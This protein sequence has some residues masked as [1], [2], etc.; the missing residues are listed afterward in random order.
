MI[1]KAHDRF[2][3]RILQYTE[4]PML[5]L[6]NQKLQAG[7]KNPFPTYMTFDPDGGDF[8]ED[9]SSISEFPLFKSI[10]NIGT[11]EHIWD[12]HGAYSNTCRMI[13]IGGVYAGTVPC[14]GYI[15]H[16]IHVT[17][18]KYIIDFLQL[19]GFTIL[20]EWLTGRENEV[21]APLLKGDTL[22][23][24]VAKKTKDV[25]EFAKPQQIFRGGVRAREDIAR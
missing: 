13:E 12:V 8:Q 23:W 7:Y 6:G 14:G 25:Q 15:N 20:D 10:V 17:K 24:V 3:K 11:I 4:T 16:G 5:M 19:N 1:I 22:S 18:H 2:Y 21:T 9:L